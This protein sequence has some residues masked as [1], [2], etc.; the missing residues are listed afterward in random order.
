MKKR[1][2]F[3]H[4]LDWPWCHE[5]RWFELRKPATRFYLAS[6]LLP[7]GIKWPVVNKL[8]VEFYN[9]GMNDREVEWQQQRLWSG[10]IELN[11]LFNGRFWGNFFAASRRDNRW[12]LTKRFPFV[13]IGLPCMQKAAAPKHDL[14][15]GVS[16]K[17]DCGWIALRARRASEGKH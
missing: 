16:H 14:F 5:F 9:C 3:Y 15:G 8:F 7:L 6:F 13:R 2:K 11:S 4:K 17:K 1:T 12:P 10:T